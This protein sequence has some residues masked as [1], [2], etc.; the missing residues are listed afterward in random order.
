M[1]EEQLIRAAMEGNAMAAHN[2]GYYYFFTKH[3]VANG[4]KWL[5]KS[6]ESGEALSHRVLGDIYINGWGVQADVKKGLDLYLKAASLGDIHA[7]RQAAQIYMR[8]V[9]DYKDIDKAIELLER[10]ANTDTESSF[11]LSLALNMK[12]GMENCYS[13][14][15]AERAFSCM[16]NAAS[17]DDSDAI[18]CIAYAYMEGR[19]VLRDMEMARSWFDKALAKNHRVEDIN[20]ILNKYFSGDMNMERY[21]CYAYWHSIVENNMSKIQ[22]KEKYIDDEG[23]LNPSAVARGAAQL[24]EVNAAALVGCSL[25]DTDPEE[26]WKYLK[27][28]ID[29]GYTSFADIVGNKYLNGDNV[30]KDDLRAY[31]YFK[32]GAEHGDLHC[33]LSLGLMCTAEGVTKE[34]E[35]MGKE[36]LLSVC[37]MAIENSDEYNSA[38]DRLNRL[39]QRDKPSI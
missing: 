11:I 14:E 23:Y 18:Y 1:N 13:W 24:G 34:T 26:A 25:L 39:D 15:L 12:C 35:E 22:R 6:A 38:K 7:A 16:L 19:G 20:Y 10:L 4:L 28:I 17:A 27:Y 36:M 8:G 21:P 5:N 2:L 31:E 33:K 30:K 37:E 32:L 3:D 9:K 29:K